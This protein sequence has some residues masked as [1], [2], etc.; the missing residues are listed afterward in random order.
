ML[1]FE[2]DEAKNRANK[3]KHRVS[4]EEAETVFLDDWG[5]LI[6]DAEDDEERFILIGT[7][8]A[9]RVLLV[10]HTYRSRDQVIRLISARR[11]NRTERRQYERRWKR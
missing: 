9:T 1:R 2:W 8:G 3:R 7:S 4:F 5:V 6:K 10:C 11:A